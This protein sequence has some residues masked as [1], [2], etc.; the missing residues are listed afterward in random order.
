MKKRFLFSAFCFLILV[1]GCEFSQNKDNTQ[2]EDSKKLEFS[3]PLSRN[4]ELDSL[5]Q[6]GNAYFAKEW[7]ETA[8]EYYEDALTICEKNNYTERLSYLYNRISIIYENLCEIEKALEFS[9]KANEVNSED[10]N[11]LIHL[12]I[13]LELEHQYDNARGCY[14]KAMTICE[15]QNN[16]LLMGIV[17]YHLGNNALFVFDLERVEKYAGQSIEINRETGN[18]RYYVAC[19]ILFSKLE[20]LK[21]HYKKSE[22]YVKNALQIAVEYDFQTIKKLCY[23]ILSELSIAQH[24]YSENMNYWKELSHIDFEITSEYTHLAILEHNAKFEAARKEFE[25][26][27][28]QHIIKQQDTQRYYFEISIVVCLVL[29]LLLWYLLRLR[30]HHNRVLTETN[31]VKD[32]FFS[33]ISHDLKNPAIMQKNAIEQIVDNIFTWDVETLADFCRTLLKSAELQVELLYNLLNWA[34]MQTGKMPFLPTTFNL[35]HSLRPEMTLIN[36][37]ANNKEIIFLAQMPEEAT[38]TADSNM[39]NTVVRNLL[40]NAVKFTHKGGQVTLEISRCIDEAH[41]IPTGLGKARLA[42]TMYKISVTDT[43]IGMNKEQIQKL[44]CLDCVCTN[45]GTADEMGSGLGLIVCKEL[46]E[47]HGSSLHVESEEGKGSRFWFV[48]SSENN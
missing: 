29:V 22:E 45:K 19:L 26:E 36:M 13:V 48:L 43:G 34:Q 20:E 37:I 47:K 32:K 27:R 38:V 35:I 17:T 10:P 24:K 30:T 21:G 2:S 25:I 44:F 11:A 40:T 9:K 31:A 4:P 42:Q 23:L 41:N 5:I 12:G 8:L 3:R 33:I 18:S 1:T 15:Q 14:E 7:Y 6:L 39:I 46:L 28:Q 16:Q